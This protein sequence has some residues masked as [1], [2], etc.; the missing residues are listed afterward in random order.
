M[1]I[2]KYILSKTRKL[3]SHPEITPGKEDWSM[4]NSG[5]VEV[6]V[7]EFLYSLIRMIKPERIL[8]TGTHLGVSSLYMA[9]G[10]QKNSKGKISTFEVIPELRSQ[11]VSLWKDFNVESFIDSNLIPSLSASFSS[12]TIFDILFLDSEPQYRFDEFKLF[13]PLLKPGGL[14]I[15]HD[16]HGSL[17]HHG[18]TYHDLYDWPYG[19][20]RESL[21][22]YITNHQVQLISFNTPR[23]MT[24]FQKE[25]EEF[26]GIKYLKEKLK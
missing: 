16:L 19:D 14:I 18:Q 2:T 9:L 20:F 6:E 26:E 3:I 12:D 22:P 8:E 5:G 15:I 1:D 17:G 21:G 23:G 13:F 11:A 24:L 10:L 25:S 4:F 7:A